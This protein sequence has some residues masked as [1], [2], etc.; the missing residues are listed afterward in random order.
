MEECVYL[1]KCFI[2]AVSLQVA[3]ESSRILRVNVRTGRSAFASVRH[4]T[5]TLTALE[6]RRCPHFRHRTRPGER[7]SGVGLPPCRRRLFRRNQT[8]TVGPPR[9]L[10]QPGAGSRRINASKSCRGKSRK[11]ELHVP[12]TFRLLRGPLGYDDAA[13]LRHD[14]GRKLG[15]QLPMRRKSRFYTKYIFRHGV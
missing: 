3:P 8:D 6:L 10:R 9:H 12:G 13:L 14:D 15:I 4:Q 5:R 2:L 1:R 7:N 11:R